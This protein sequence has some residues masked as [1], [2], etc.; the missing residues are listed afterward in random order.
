MRISD[1]RI[2]VH[3]AKLHK[4]RPFWLERH[5]FFC[6][7]VL[8][9]LDFV[10]KKISRETTSKY[11]FSFQLIQ[12]ISIT[13]I[14]SYSHARLGILI[15]GECPSVDTENFSSTLMKKHKQSLSELIRRDKNR[16]SVIM[17]SIANEPRTQ[18]P[19]A[20]FYF[21]QIAQHTKNLDSSRPVTIAL[22][23]SVSV[24]KNQFSIILQSQIK[25]LALLCCPRMIKLESI[26]I[27]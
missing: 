26:W 10:I 25:I 21:K 12:K 17:W 9:K 23:R 2:Q 18:L 4:I 5:E 3:R 27:L 1:A 20:G 13:L 22:A 11:K 15:I 8:S 16:P 24:I 14:T 19:D 6:N 7:S